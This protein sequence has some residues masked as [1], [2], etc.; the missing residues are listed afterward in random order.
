MELLEKY[1]GSIVG[2]NVLITPKESQ[3]LKPQSS[4]MEVW[5]IFEIF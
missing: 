1:F 5:H 4:D 3:G 2:A